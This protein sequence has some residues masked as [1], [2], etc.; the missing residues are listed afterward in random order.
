MAAQQD[1]APDQT[2]PAQAPTQPEQKTIWKD[3]L[4]GVTSAALMPPQS[5]PT[6][7][8]AS[9][10]FGVGD[11]QITLNGGRELLA[12]SRDSDGVQQAS[13]VKNSGQG[14]G[15]SVD[16]LGQVKGQD[17]YYIRT[18]DG[19]S[20]YK[21]EGTIKNPRVTELRDGENPP[22]GLVGGS[23]EAY[24]SQDNNDGGD[25]SSVLKPMG[26]PAVGYDASAFLAGKGW[27]KVTIDQVANGQIVR[28]HDKDKNSY[29]VSG[30]K[31]VPDGTF[32]P[33]P[34]RQ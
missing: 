24:A 13:Y 15:G 34:A 30:G 10:L 18:S 11:C 29:K 3:R 33:T 26:A 22:A 32:T 9:T 27:Q 17:I 7:C 8:T 31:I 20:T 21:V 25:L 2:A 16:Y 4:K 1:T 28:F 5:Q 6:D 12:W 19:I 14:R 23:E